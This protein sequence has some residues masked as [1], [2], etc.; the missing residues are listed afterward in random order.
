MKAAAAAAF[1]AAK[2]EPDFDHHKLLHTSQE[3]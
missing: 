3:A 1:R 2:W